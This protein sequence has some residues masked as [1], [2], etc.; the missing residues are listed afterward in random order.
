MLARTAV[1]LSPSPVTPNETAKGK[2]MVAAVMTAPAT[3]GFKGMLC[4]EWRALGDRGGYCCNTQVDGR[5]VERQE[6]DDK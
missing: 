3:M 5:V 6:R 2:A 1:E 4:L